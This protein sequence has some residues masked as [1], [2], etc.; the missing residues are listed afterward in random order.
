MVIFGFEP[1]LERVKF[2]TGTPK[3][4]NVRLAA[5]D[6][7]RNARRKYIRLKVMPLSWP[8]G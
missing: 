5:Q 4:R 1:S 3:H 8:L 6:T 2:R 7:F